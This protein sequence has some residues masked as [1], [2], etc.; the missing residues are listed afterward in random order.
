MGPA[1]TAY[2][3]PVR[4]GAQNNNAGLPRA[5]TA[6]PA[7]PAEGSPGSGTEAGE[8][9]PSLLR[10]L[11][12]VLLLV[13]VLDFVS[14]GWLLGCDGAELAVLAQVR[15]RLARPIPVPYV[16]RRPSAVGEPAPAARAHRSP[17]FPCCGFPFLAPPFLFPSFFPA[18]GEGGVPAGVANRVQ[19]RLAVVTAEAPEGGPGRIVLAR[20]LQRGCHDWDAAVIAVEAALADPAVL[21]VR[22]S[23]VGDPRH[24]PN[25]KLKPASYEL[26]KAFFTRACVHTNRYTPPCVITEDPSP[27]SP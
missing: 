23:K 10:G 14:F 21:P 19:Q 24:L 7:P 8:P 1:P 15:V 11:L 9:A 25:F 3:L 13:L 26:H 6:L 16:A 18:A 17:G 22:A 20:Q 27:S 12:G 4:Q 5:A 2:A